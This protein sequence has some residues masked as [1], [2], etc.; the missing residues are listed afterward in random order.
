MKYKT[1]KEGRY[2]VVELM[3]D[4]D[5]SCSVDARKVI[6]EFLKGGRNVLVELSQVT[7]IDSSGV[8]SLVEGYQTAR[9]KELKFGLVGVSDAALSVIQLARLDKVFPIHATV[10]ERLREDG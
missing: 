1:R 10:E 3:G 6:L 2:T 7:Y 8:A 9:K 5:L 4:V